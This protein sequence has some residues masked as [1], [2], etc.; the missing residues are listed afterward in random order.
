MSQGLGV[1]FLLCS[2]LWA[3]FVEAIEPIRVL[4]FQ[5]A[6]RV[7][8]SA[9]GGV[10]VRFLSGESWISREPLTFIA[11]PKGIS[12]NGEEVSAES[13]T[14]RG[15][16][17][18]LTISIRDEFRGSDP[19]RS[20]EQAAVFIRSLPNGP[21]A[22]PQPGPSLQLAEPMGT[23]VVSGMAQVMR[24][25]QGFAVINEVELEEYVKGVVSSE[26]SSSWHQEALKVQA[27]AT[28][29]YAL[30]QRINNAGRPYDVVASTQDQVYRG[31]HGL[32]PRVQ[33]AVEETRG[34]VITYQNALI[35]AAFSSTAAGPTEEA[36]NV[37][38]KDLPYLK[39]VECPFDMNS[40][41]YQWRSAFTLEKL[42]TNL[43]QKGF[44]VGTIASLTPFSYSQ[45]GRV[46]KMRVL[47]STGELILRGEDLRRVMGYRVIPS[48][49]FE[50]DAVGS[51]VVLMGYGAGHAV[52]LCQW[53]AKEL[54]ELGYSFFAIL[55]Y[56][57]PGTELQE[58]WSTQLIP[59]SADVTDRF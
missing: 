15:L 3:S 26:V 6:Q 58:A 30:Y 45:A 52:G 42:E 33:Q 25:G 48:T 28:R 29:T 10:V 9:Q 21:I 37:W 59:P 13:V 49:H 23:I 55:R 2:V 11:L 1:S 8:V 22:E 19:G 34:I 5:D 39:G 32:S 36:V 24:H 14:I 16:E 51:D 35:L 43:R 53:G 17:H 56:Y 40:P 50:I 4:L 27:V 44:V 7:E 47:H 18:D 41:Y 20:T 54:A 31:R 12:V 57:Y 38:S 46:L